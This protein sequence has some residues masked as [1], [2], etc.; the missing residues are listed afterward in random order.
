[1]IKGEKTGYQ[2]FLLFQKYFLPFPKETAIFRSLLRFRLLKPSIS[3]RLNFCCLI[4]LNI[5][6][7]GKKN[8]HLVNF[9]FLNL[10][11]VILYNLL[12]LSQT[13]PGVYVSAVQVF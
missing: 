1:M 2:R 7:I 5:V 11:V 6:L 4:E 8:T 9:F 10:A 12:T 13:S 3:N